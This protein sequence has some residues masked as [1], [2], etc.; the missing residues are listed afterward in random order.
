MIVDLHSH[1]ST[2][3]MFVK[4]E[5][6]CEK[7]YNFLSALPL[8]E[9]LAEDALDSQS[10]L[11]QVRAG[12][13]KIIINPIYSLERCLARASLIYGFMSDL[14]IS[15]EN[16]LHGIA[17]GKI[18]N[19][20]QT[21]K[22]FNMVKKTP[23][24]NLLTKSN[25]KYDPNTVNVLH[26]IEGIQGVFNSENEFAGK[27]QNHHFLNRLKLVVDQ[28][29]PVYFTLSHMTYNGIFNY[30]FGMK[31]TSEKNRSWFLPCDCG[32]EGITG[33]RKEVLDLLRGEDVLFDVKH[34]S[35]GNRIALYAYAL[36]HNI[37]VII[38]H[39]AVTGL[40]VGDFL[41]HYA[42]GAYKVSRIRNGKPF[43]KMLPDKL[44]CKTI[45]PRKKGVYNHWF[46]STQL[47]LMDEEIVMIM[48]LGGLIGLIFDRRV[49]GNV[50]L[51]DLANNQ[52]L[53]YLSP[54]DIPYIYGHYNDVLDQM[55]M[56]SKYHL[57]QSAEAI[58]KVTSHWAHVGNQIDKKA[59]KSDN[60]EKADLE[61]FCQQIIHIIQVGK[62][63]G[64]ANP[65]NHI[66]I[67]S[68]YDGL[69]AAV[70]CAKTAAEMT[71]FRD[72]V[73]DELKEYRKQT[74]S[75]LKKYNIG[76]D[77]LVNGIFGENAFRFLE[78]RGRV[79]QLIT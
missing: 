18:M 39:G 11:S 36:K 35:L 51:K 65:E 79:Q 32:I 54:E 26:A 74:G 37:P 42:A 41:S 20:V 40:T 9:W 1:I 75:V 55:G 53:D 59:A 45:I 16:V 4:G 12:G 72:M 47:N 68:D 7:A 17:D 73:R 77:R 33:L 61:R 64:I 56:D 62:E 27:F 46:N 21:G 24:I 3:P 69:I 38:S 34:L 60:T 48:K 25:T 13:G 8:D 63:N 14:L 50:K 19:Y 15:D 44:I 78:S 76:V 70:K 5:K 57:S 52:Y 58:D 10:S 31:M 29:E 6:N 66:A 2:K 28:I 43:H 22:E 49:L 67:G 71:S 30:P 23:N